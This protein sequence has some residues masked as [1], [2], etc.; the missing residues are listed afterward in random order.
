VRRIERERTDRLVSVCKRIDRSRLARDLAVGKKF[1]EVEHR[2]GVAHRTAVY[3][4]PAGDSSTCS[5]ASAS[6]LVRVFPEGKRSDRRVVPL[7]T[8][9]EDAIGDRQ[10]PLNAAYG[11]RDHI[12]DLQPRT[13]VLSH[14]VQ[15]RYLDVSGMNL[16]HILRSLARALFEARRGDGASRALGE[17]RLFARG[18]GGL[19][20]LVLG[21]LSFNNPKVLDERPHHGRIQLSSRVLTPE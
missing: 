15:R 18:K 6:D 10:H 5:K 14:L 3:D 1:L 4:D 11:Q 12:A 20:R 16:L 7:P 8:Q 2:V 21:D 17:P 13:Q 19:S 9:V